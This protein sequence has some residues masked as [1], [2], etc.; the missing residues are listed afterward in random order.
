MASNVI[1]GVRDEAHSG[2]KYADGD[3]SSDIFVGLKACFVEVPFE[4]YPEYLGTALWFY[5]KSPQPFPC[6]QLVWPDR[7]G[8]FPWES[9]CDARLRK[10]Q[11]ILKSIS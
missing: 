3:V 6:L 1:N 2:K 7:S 11:P 10:D 8:R 4:Q 9:G 5:R